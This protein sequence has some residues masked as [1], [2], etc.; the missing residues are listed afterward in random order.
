ME[1]CMNRAIRRHHSNRL[2]QN[3]RYY[4]GQDKAEVPR[5]LGMVVTTAALCSCAMCGNP[6]KYFGDR[7]IQEQRAMQDVAD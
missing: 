4:H 1:K 5:N 6:R 7:S 3:R 2:K